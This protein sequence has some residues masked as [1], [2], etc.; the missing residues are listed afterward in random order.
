MIDFVIY[1]ASS[2][3]DDGLRHSLVTNAQYRM[4]ITST[5]KRQEEAARV[6]IREQRGFG[7][8]ARYTTRQ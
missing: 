6:V 5:D 4:S 2:Q 3:N 1:D 8:G 7:A